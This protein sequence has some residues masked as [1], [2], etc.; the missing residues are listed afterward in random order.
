MPVMIGDILDDRYKIVQPLGEGGMGA[1]YE[2][3]HLGTGRRVAVKVI[4]CQLAHT[5]LVVARFQREAR[6]A[7]T[8]ESAHIAQILDSGKDLKTGLPFLVMEYLTGQDVQQL[9]TKLGPLPPDLALRILGQACLGLAKA[10]GAKVM[11]RD[12]KPANLFLAQRDEGEL[13]IKILDFGIA[14]IK[15]DEV[16]SVQPDLTRTN[17]M[18]GSPLYMSPEQARGSKDIDYRT[19]IWSLGVVLYKLL[20]GR[21]PFE[22]VEAL[23]E[24]IIA[25]CG[26]RTPPIQG[27][28]PWVPPEVAAI[29]H[30]ALKINRAERFQS[31]LEMYEAIKALLPHGGAIQ[32]SMLVPLDADVQSLQAPRLAISEPSF[33]VNVTGVDVQGATINWTDPFP[34]ELPLE[35]AGPRSATSGASAVPQPG[36]G[37]GTLRPPTRMGSM[38]SLPQAALTTPDPTKDSTASPSTREVAGPSTESGEAIAAK[39][40]TNRKLVLGAL[41]V[42]ALGAL[43]AWTVGMAMRA[44]EPAAVASAEPSAS[45]SAAPVASPRIDPE[46][47]NSF[48]AL[49]PLVTSPTNPLTDEK[50]KLG[51][52]LFYEPRLSKNHDIACSTCHKLDSYGADGEKVPT[53]HAHQMG[54]RNTPSVYNA[55]GY[56][57]LNWDGQAQNVED[58]AKT[59]LLRA[60]E[61]GMTEQ[62]IEA[63]LRSIPDYV[64]A[65]ARAFPN[66][67]PALSYTNAARAIGAFERKLFTPGRWDKFLAGETAALTDAEKAGFNTFI[68][69]GCVTCHFGP[70]VG[71]TMFQK[72]GLVKTWPNTKDRGRFEATQI[73]TDYMVFRVPSLRN[74][75]MTGPYFHDGSISSLDEA[76]RMMAYHQLGKEI[77]PADVLSIAAWLKSLTGEIPHDYIEKP[78]LP[79]S[80]PTTPR[81]EPE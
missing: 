43:G 63:T 53:G 32:E 15:M 17:S 4:T 57:A 46:R 41:V 1:V 59:P 75:A 37:A 19:D 62:R 16:V 36:P 2:A 29:A 34:R 79:E 66:E 61:M 64:K 67:R 77:P 23:G 35:S 31:A 5:E 40:R 60:N 51:R 13:A 12:L 18:L 38:P 9:F 55:A 33:A 73:D 69:T 7:G 56:F 49:P 58:Q 28:A 47:L 42:A 50:I 54:Q 39:A 68:D 76:I 6:A 10:H 26:E 45:V 52:M 65:F 21:T 24:L 81:P 71:A 11:H 22:D 72:L 44:P 70:N 27:F 78:A 80:S 20:S 74:V 3:R 14:K 48:S 25:I 30:R 8:V